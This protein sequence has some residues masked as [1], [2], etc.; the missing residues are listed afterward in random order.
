[1]GNRIDYVEFHPSW[2]ELLRLLRREGLHALPWMEPKAGAHV[3]RAAGYF[4]HSQVEAG[5][6][7]PTTMTFAS[8][9]VLK[10][11]PEL[12]SSLQPKLYSREHDARDLPLAQKQ[13]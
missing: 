13:S 10:N 5:S 11:E 8:I 12:F 4:L 2:H 9:P 7:C 3:A 1:C 6:L